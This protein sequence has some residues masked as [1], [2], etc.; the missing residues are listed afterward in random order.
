ML[1]MKSASSF[2]RKQAR[3]AQQLQERTHHNAVNKKYTEIPAVLPVGSVKNKPPAYP[4]SFSPLQPH[5][6]AP[7]P[8]RSQPSP[9]SWRWP[10]ARSHPPSSSSS[11]SSFSFFTSSR[12]PPGRFLLA[13]AAGMEA[14]RFLAMALQRPQTPGPLV[15]PPHSPPR[16]RGRGRGRE[17]RGRAIAA[18]G[19]VFERWRMR[20]IR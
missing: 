20:W 11:S 16:R 13:V 3:T 17:G 4:S 6:T 18:R 15:C 7:V 9:R 1:N 8:P 5:T 10:P 14:L 19:R 12:G 2:C